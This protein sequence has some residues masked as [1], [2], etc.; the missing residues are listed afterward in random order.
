MP[1]LPCSLSVGCIV[2]HTPV[3]LSRLI[4]TQATP[5][6]AG[7]QAGHRGV[8]G[9]CQRAELTG[10]LIQV[11]HQHQAV[12]GWAGIEA[13]YQCTS[14]TARNRSLISVV[15]VQESSQLGAA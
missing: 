11:K 1:G 9:P 14:R 13:L 10:A 6:W 4:I 12:C 3:P 7:G 15:S 8:G 5:D 2:H